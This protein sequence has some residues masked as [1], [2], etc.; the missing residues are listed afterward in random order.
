MLFLRREIFPDGVV[1]RAE[2]G[3][4]FALAERAPDGDREWPQFFEEVAA[5]FFLNEEEPRGYITDGDFEA[6]K[7]LVTAEGVR[8]STL[9]LRLLISL[10]EKAVATPPRMRD[11]VADEFRRLVAEKAAEERR[12]SPEDT[13]ILRRFLYAAGGDNA[14][15]VTREEAELLFDLHD[16]TADADNDPAW[17]ELFAKAIAA[18]L[19][20]HVGY[21]PLPREEALRLHEWMSDHSVNPARFLQQTLAGGLQALREAYGRKSVWTRR[22]EDDAI[23]A[24]I[25]EE[26]TAREADWLADR[27][28][29][30]GKTDDAEKALIDYMR[31]LEAD[32]PPKLKALVSEAA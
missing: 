9:E 16:M 27:I 26:V 4:I 11:F 14:V 22:N 20:Q 8:A 31:E 15:G 1:S 12:I 19:M 25:A 10:L 18:H 23:A 6:L 17:V 21:K 13:E 28:G 24:E 5:D 32:L 30:N 29:R 7:A 2:I 3:G